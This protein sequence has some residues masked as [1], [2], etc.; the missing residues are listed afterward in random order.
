[1]RR[2]ASDVGALRGLQERLDDAWKYGVSAARIGSWSS[3]PTQLSASRS[4]AKHAFPATYGLSGSASTS[5]VR[6]SFRFAGVTTGGLA[7][8][9]NSNTRPMVHA[10]VSRT[11]GFSSLVALSRNGRACAATGESLFGSGPSRMEPNAN[12]AASR[13]RHSPCEMFWWMNG[14]TWGTMWSL[15]H[16]ATRLRH[17]PPAIATFH[18]SSPSSTWSSSCFVS[19]SRSIGTRCGRACWTN[20]SAHFARGGALILDLLHDRHLL[21]AHRGPE[22]DRLQSHGLLVALGGFGREVEDGRDV[23]LELV[24]ATS[25]TPTRTS[26]AAWR[27]RTSAHT[28]ASHVTCMM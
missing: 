10:V 4:R 27:T 17:V 13:R 20:C 23:G 3:S 15:T 9:T 28:V 2:L 11:C 16:V 12:V 1:M 19:V 22:L 26:Y 5:L 18:A 25:A 24:V 21:L 6:I 8:P 14:R 7:P